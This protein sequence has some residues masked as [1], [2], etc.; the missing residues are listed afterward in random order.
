M[1]G[2]I[3]ACARSTGAMLPRC[4]VAERGRASSRL[5]RGNEFPREKPSGAS[6]ARGVDKREQSTKPVRLF[7]V[8]IIARC[9]ARSASAMCR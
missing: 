7:R 4:S 2:P 8:A 3:D 5:Q 9:S 1:P 6:T